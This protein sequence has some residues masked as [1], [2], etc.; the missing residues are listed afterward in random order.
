MSSADS[1]RKE[2]SKQLCKMLI[3]T[4][5]PLCKINNPIFKSFF[6]T[7]TKFD[8]PNESTLRKNYIPPLYDESMSRVKAELGNTPIWVSLDETTDTCGRHVFN[9][10]AGPLD[11]SDKVYLIDINFF[12]KTNHST[13]AQ[14]LMSALQ[15]NLQRTH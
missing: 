6:N 1:S 14:A 9:V 15:K 10:V 3:A 11:S 8:L 7:Y 2:F 12:E 13:A 4:D 5:I